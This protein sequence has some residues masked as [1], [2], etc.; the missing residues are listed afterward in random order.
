MEPLSMALDVER[1]ITR[2]SLRKLRLVLSA[3]AACAGIL[4]SVAAFRPR[5]T[6]LAVT[7]RPGDDTLVV[8]QTH[9]TRIRVSV[10]DQYGRPISADSVLHYEWLSGDST[11]LSPDG[12]LRC[13]SRGAAVVRATFETL[14]RDFVLRCRPVARIEAASWLD[15]VAGDSAR[16]LSFVARAPDGTRETELRGTV[17][18]GDQ[19]VATLQGTTIRPKRAGATVALIQ[20]GDAKVAIPILVY[21][22]VTSFTDTSAARGGLLAMRVSVARG[23]TL[24]TPLPRAAFWVTYI[25]GDPMVAPPTIE[26]RGEG[27]CTSGDGVRQRRIEEGQYAKYCYAGAGSRMMIAHGVVG[28]ETVNGVVALRLMW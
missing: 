28:A 9:L 14:S 19:S 15:L 6:G 26:L 21:R 13:E 7:T 11:S 2:R 20:A 22:L 17:T 24:L 25:S 4:G 23:D 5:A 18:V 12:V 10:L 16:D 27:A 3:G 8:N 1:R